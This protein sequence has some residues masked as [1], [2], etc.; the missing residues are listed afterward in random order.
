MPTVRA[1]SIKPK[2]KPVHPDVRIG[3]VHL[4]AADLD[5]ALAFY[6]DVLGFELRQRYGQRAAF[7]SAGGYH[8]PPAA[9]FERRKPDALAF[10]AGKVFVKADG[11]DRAVPF[12]DLLRRANVRLATGSESTFGNPKPKFSMHSY[13]SHFVE[14]TWQPEMLKAVTEAALT[15]R[16]R[17]SSTAFPLK[18]TR[19][20]TRSWLH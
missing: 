6:R 3:H 20:W 8:H 11:P 15:A 7:L 12:A 2:L 9:P 5:R 14:V 10:E 13:G 18:A 16:Q 4:K 1:I 17:F 19:M